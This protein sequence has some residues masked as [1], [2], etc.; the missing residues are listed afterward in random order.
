[1]NGEVPTETTPRRTGELWEISPELRVVVAENPGPLTLDGTRTYV[2]GLTHLAIVDP[3]PAQPTHLRR[4]IDAVEGRPVGRICLTHAHPDHAAGAAEAAE[5]LH[6]GLCASAETLGRLNLPGDAVQEGEELPLDAGSGGSLRV[7]ETPGHSADSLSYLWLPSRKLFTGDL[8]LGGGTSVVVHPDGAVGPYLASLAKL[9]AL[10]PSVILPGH[11][12]PV[13]E[14]IRRLE[15]YRRHRIEREREI[16]AAV[17][18]GLVALGEIRHRVYGDLPEELER[19][20]ELSILA[21]LLHL[22]EAGE[23]LPQPLRAAVDGRSLPE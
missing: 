19:A 16:R 7:V 5:A 3:G 18:G 22:A 1:M 4:V 21:H 9:I 23:A 10:R 12:E 20:A 6:A 15:G 11:G 2:V 17:R 13:E 8:V 14:P